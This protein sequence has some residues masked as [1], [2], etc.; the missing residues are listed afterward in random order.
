MCI[1]VGV[2]TRVVNA[3][4]IAVVVTSGAGSLEDIS[5]LIKVANPSGIAL[6]SLLHYDQLTI[7]DIRNYLRNEGLMT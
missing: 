1:D 3:V 7:K 4:D 6:A 5:K 2:G